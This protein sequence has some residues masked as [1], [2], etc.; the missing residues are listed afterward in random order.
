M[1]HGAL[2][3]HILT[4]KYPAAFTADLVVSQAIGHSNQVGVICMHIYAYD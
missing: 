4:R 3:T 1:C 2:K